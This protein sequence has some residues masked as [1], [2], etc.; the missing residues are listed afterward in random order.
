MT[1]LSIEQ[2]LIETRRKFHQYPEISFKEF[3]T[4]SLILTFLKDNQIEFKYPVG[5]NG[6]LARIQGKEK[7]PSLGF[8][9]EM[10]AL[11]LTENNSC[12]Y[13]S[14]N[15]GVMHACGHDAHLS[16]LIHFLLYIK[17]KSES[18]TMK[19]E[20]IGIFQYAEESGLGGAIEMCND[21]WILN[22]DEIYALHVNPSYP[23]GT[24]I[25]KNGPLYAGNLPFRI[26]FKGKSGHSS[27]PLNCK[28]ALSCMCECIQKV[29]EKL[30]SNNQYL[31]DFVYNFGYVKSGNARNIIPGEAEFGGMIRSYSDSLLNQVFSEIKNLCSEY[32]EKAQIEFSF[33]RNEGYKNVYNNENLYQRVKKSTI[34]CNYTF[35]ECSPIFESENFSDFLSKN[36]G[37]I[38]FLGCQLK[39][40]FVPLHN[41]CF[42]ID[43][44]CLR[45][46][47]NM[48]I[49]IIETTGILENSSNS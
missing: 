49:K 1:N 45:V 34:D 38:F 25:C 29:N 13:F 47:L 36:N 14:K 41:E 23:V 18:E 33:I 30:K 40:G 31:K 20:I 43:E 2:S 12:S 11:S 26:F 19:G 3:N 22:L 21:P 48:F 4:A 6:I 10:D 16:I 42:D 37:C 28:D 8:R 32:C 7:G 39:S 35:L 5:A 15:T 44:R 46:G 9:C 24:V 27:D 17:N